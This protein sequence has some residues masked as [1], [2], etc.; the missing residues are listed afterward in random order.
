MEKSCPL[1]LL[2]STLINFYI[3]VASGVKI[4]KIVEKFIINCCST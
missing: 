4:L 2:L 3:V 1:I